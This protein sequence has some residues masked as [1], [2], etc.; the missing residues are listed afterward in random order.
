MGLTGPIS[1]SFSGEITNGQIE[2]QAKLELPKLTWV[3]V[4]R[5]C[6]TPILLFALLLK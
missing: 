4:A 6:I 2:V 1:G 5:E 3:D